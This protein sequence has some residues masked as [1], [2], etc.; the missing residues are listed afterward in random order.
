ML[1]QGNVRICLPGYHG[2]ISTAATFRHVKRFIFT[3]LQPRKSDRPILH[4]S[5]DPP[6][7][8]HRRAPRIRRVRQKGRSG[9]SWANGHRPALA[10]EAGGSG[11]TPGGALHRRGRR[12]GLAGGGKPGR[13]GASPLLLSP[14]HGVPPAS[15]R[16]EA[17]ATAPGRPGPHEDP[18]PPRY[19][20]RS[21]AAMLPS[22][23]AGP[24]P[25][26]PGGAAG[27]R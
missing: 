20:R 7:L 15:P 6:A 12:A 22:R 27:P 9:L 2:G 16:T 19:S 5:S 3:F 4:T 8:Q 1:V 14:P 25:L 23:P 26:P 10:A 21:A 17:A 18:H 13:P 24:L 11:Q